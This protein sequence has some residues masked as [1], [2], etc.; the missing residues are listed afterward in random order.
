MLGPHPVNA[1]RGFCFVDHIGGVFPSGFLTVECGNVRRQPVS[2]IYRTSKVF[3]EL[4]DTSLLKGRCGRCE[5]RDMCSGGS[6]ARA[7]AITGDY[8]AEDPL[9]GYQPAGEVIRSP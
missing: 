9:C 3:N 6:R 5:Y 8:L 7:Y 1:G 2:E 4:R